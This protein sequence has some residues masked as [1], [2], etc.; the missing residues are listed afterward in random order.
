MKVGDEIEINQ[1]IFIFE[2]EQFTNETT[3]YTVNHGTSFVFVR[4]LP[5][6]FQ[7]RILLE[8]FGQ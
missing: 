1:R 5:K 4:K 3:L 6:F 7:S 2:T 8:A